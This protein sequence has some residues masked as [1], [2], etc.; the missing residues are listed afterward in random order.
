MPD[1]KIL[2]IRSTRYFPVRTLIKSDQGTEFW[3]EVVNVR[4]Y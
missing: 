4:K 1:I 2:K 3:Q